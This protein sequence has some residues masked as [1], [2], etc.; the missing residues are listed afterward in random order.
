[1]AAFGDCWKLRQ[2]LQTKHIDLVVIGGV[3]VGEPQ[4]AGGNDIW[5]PGRGTPS[6][7]GSDRECAGR[8]TPSMWW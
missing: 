2:C 5:C 6:R 7:L 8:G 1:M 3:L 4:V